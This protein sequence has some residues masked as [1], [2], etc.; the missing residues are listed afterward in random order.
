MEELNLTRLTGLDNHIDDLILEEVINGLEDQARA[1][2]MVATTT[3][4]NKKEFESLEAN[5]HQIIEWLRELQKYRKM[6][7][8]DRPSGEVD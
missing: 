2:S 7:P 5:Y 8:Q 3:L 6:Y 4:S 1:Y